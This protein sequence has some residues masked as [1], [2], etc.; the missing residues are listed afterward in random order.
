MLYTAYM[1]IATF[2]PIQSHWPCKLKRSHGLTAGCTSIHRPTVC[3]YCCTLLD[4]PVPVQKRQAV[5]YTAYM[6]I[7]TF[8][9]NLISAIVLFYGGHLVLGG[10]MSAGDLVSFMLYQQSLASTFQVHPDA[11]WSSLLAVMACCGCRL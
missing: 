8:L 4:K 2:L 7:A 5:L 10:A 1:V 11:D 3:H 6:V 9:P